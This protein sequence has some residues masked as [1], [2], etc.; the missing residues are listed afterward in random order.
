MFLAVVEVG[1][2]SNSGIPLYIKD[3]QH[4]KNTKDE[5]SNIMKSAFLSAIS[6]M[7]DISFNDESQE[8]K[9]KNHII[10]TNKTK[11]NY[12]IY[13]V[14][15]KDSKII[16]PLKETVKKIAAHLNSLEALNDLQ[17]MKNIELLDDYIIE[18]FN[19][20]QKTSVDRIKNIF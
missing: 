9:L 11:L 10:I 15:D 3:F 17:P 6:S 19:D 18:L 16:F 7:L 13:I 14:A 4:K 2:I 1:I 5:Q 12:I 20:L 8:I